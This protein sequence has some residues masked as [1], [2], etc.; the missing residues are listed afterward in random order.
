MEKQTQ[1]IENTSKIRENFKFAHPGDQVIAIERHCTAMYGSSLWDLRGK[2]VQS[3]YSSWKTAI[4]LAWGVHRGCRSYLLQ[5]VL[6]PGVP[7]MKV[8]LLTRFL[9]FFHSLLSSPSK[10][11]TVAVRLAARDVRSNLGSNL[12]WIRE[13]TNMDP[14]SINKSTLRSLLTLVETETPTEADQWRVPY[15]ASLL[16]Q[17]LYYHYNAHNEMETIMSRVYSFACH[18]LDGFFL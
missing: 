16:D 9:G 13:E 17:R 8:K 12:A 18:Q 6:A 15:L 5:S 3:V 7:S 1:F 10:E 11:I 2:C 4:K 14:W